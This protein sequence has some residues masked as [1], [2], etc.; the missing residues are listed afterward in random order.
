[1]DVMWRSVIDLLSAAEIKSTTLPDE[2][3]GMFPRTKGSSKGNAL[4]AHK[5]GCNYKL[6]KPSKC[7][8]MANALSHSNSLNVND[9]KWR[10]RQYSGLGTK[11]GSLRRACKSKIG[12]RVQVDPKTTI[13]TRS[14]Q[15]RESCLLWRLLNY[16]MHALTCNANR[17][18]SIS[19]HCCNTAITREM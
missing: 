2:V 5:L 3:R 7:K 11:G 16:F 17:G 14:Y 10:H 9:D 1:M 12:V 4:G 15:L 8:R 6:T 19:C 18:M 13:I